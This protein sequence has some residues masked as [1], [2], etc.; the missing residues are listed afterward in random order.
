MNKR[1]ADGPVHKR[2]RLPL[3]VVGE[4]NQSETHGDDCAKEG[5]SRGMQ[6][7]LRATPSLPLL[8][9][10]LEARCA[11]AWGVAPPVPSTTSL[12]RAHAQAPVAPHLVQ[13]QGRLDAALAEAIRSAGPSTADVDPQVPRSPLVRM[14]RMWE[15]A[16]AA[17]G[18]DSVGEGVSG[19]LVRQALHELQQPPPRSEPGA[20]GGMAAPA[21]G[22][23]V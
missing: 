16:H 7:L 11:E 19:L 6:L 14:Q 17:G 22:S 4:T 12:A 23:V 13:L 8:P 21:A 3:R 2:P 9:E 5:V 1:A 15:D 10:H 18:K 20:C